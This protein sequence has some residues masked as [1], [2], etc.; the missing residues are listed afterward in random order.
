MAVDDM[1][2]E[3]TRSDEVGTSF[4]DQSGWIEFSDDCF[5]VRPG[6]YHRCDH[7]QAGDQFSASL[8]RQDGLRRIGYDYRQCTLTCSQLFKNGYMG[9][10]QRVEVAHDE[11]AVVHRGTGAGRNLCSCIQKSFGNC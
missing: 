2:S 5:G 4:V 8:Q 3:L 1:R 7:P 6:S 11:S 10:M 9:C